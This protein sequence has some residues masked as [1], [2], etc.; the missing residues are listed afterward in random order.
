MK[1]RITKEDLLPLE[2]FTKIRATKRQETISI[3][4]NRRLPLGQEATLFF[5]NYDTLWWQIQEMLYI[6]KGG[7]AQAEDELLA[8]N[9][10]LPQGQELVATF[11]IEIDDPVRRAQVLG[12]LGGIEYHLTIRFCN[13]ILKGAPEEDPSRTTES[14]KTSAIHFIHWVFSKDQIAD[15]SKP[16]QDIVVEITHPQFTIKTLMPEAVRAALQGDFEE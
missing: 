10:L 13:H 7:D 2:E 12:V 9:P 8:Y 14:G 11:M 4:K 6:E 3:K 5:E 15:F 1:K 16:H